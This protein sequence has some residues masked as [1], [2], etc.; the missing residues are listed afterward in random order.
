M[1]LT[2]YNELES[3]I[4]SIL[5]SEFGVSETEAREINSSRSQEEYTAKLEEIIARWEAKN[6]EDER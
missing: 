1:I 2:Q 6:A 4:T 3:K 5:F